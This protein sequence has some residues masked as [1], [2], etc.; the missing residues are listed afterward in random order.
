MTSTYRRRFGG[1]PYKLL[2]PVDSKAAAKRSV[3]PQSDV[4]R[5]KAK[6]R[7]VKNTKANRDEL[8][9]QQ[10]SWRKKKWSVYIRYD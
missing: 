9:E 7:I 3:G 2:W 1:K 8:A 5:T 6:Y 10:P 4:A